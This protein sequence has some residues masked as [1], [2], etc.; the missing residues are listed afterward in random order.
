MPLSEKLPNPSAGFLPWST[1]S[2]YFAL[3]AIALVL[4]CA[5][6]YN[7]S[8]K[9]SEDGSQQARTTP[10]E[11]EGAALSQEQRGIKAPKQIKSETQP[12]LAPYPPLPPISDA[13]GAVLSRQYTVSSA[14]DR[15]TRTR[16][17]ASQNEEIPQF[18]HQPQSRQGHSSYYYQ[19]SISYSFD[20][21]RSATTATCRAP[22]YQHPRTLNH[23]DNNTNTSFAREYPNTFPPPTHDT[24]HPACE[25]HFLHESAKPENY[26]DLNAAGQRHEHSL[27]PIRKQRE[28]LQVFRGVGQEKGRTWRR[29]VLEYS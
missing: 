19:D 8:C 18:Q 23:I 24:S 11:K 25:P 13:S 2:S 16:L 6:W 5:R 17:R 26:S 1:S 21:N 28:S 20:P 29:K 12:S 14:D 10:T 15:G 3:L 9:T 22:Q 4:F 27:S 7:Q